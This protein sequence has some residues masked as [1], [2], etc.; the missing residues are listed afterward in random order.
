MKHIGST[1]RAAVALAAAAALAVPS[2]AQAQFD[3]NVQLCFST[4]YCAVVGLS[5]TGSTLTVGLRNLGSTDGTTTSR[6]T[7]IGF[8]GTGTTTLTG[9]SLA[10]QSYVGSPA[11]IPGFATNG[12]GTDLSSG[13]GTTDVVVGADFGNNGFLPVYATDQISGGFQRLATQGTGAAAEYGLFTFNLIGSNLSLANIGVGLRVQ[14]I[15]QAGLSDKCFSV[16]DA[17]CTVTTPSG[18]IGGGGQ[19]SVVPEPSTYVL[20]ASGMLGLVG[21]ARRRQRQ[22]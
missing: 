9:G 22:G 18:G 20:L 3:R 1:A 13:N 6:L 15:G 8:F 17:N 11:L 2:Q 7:E 10:T 4:S 14:S 19:G 16:G 5:L 12:N 21:V